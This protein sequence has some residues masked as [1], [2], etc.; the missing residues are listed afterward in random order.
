MTLSYV[1]VSPHLG[2]IVGYPI[3]TTLGCDGY[4]NPTNTTYLFFLSACMDLDK[5]P[6]AISGP[7]NQLEGFLP[8]GQQQQQLQPR[9]Q[10][11]PYQQQPFQ[12]QYQQQQQAPMD[13]DNAS[14]DS[15]VRALGGSRGI[16]YINEENDPNQGNNP[17]AESC[18]LESEDVY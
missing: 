14:V 6:L 4:S 1:L 13:Q 7:S 8:H 18:P 5:E 10:Q 16:E 15:L 9:S 17:P 3:L 2:G 11:Q 12:Q